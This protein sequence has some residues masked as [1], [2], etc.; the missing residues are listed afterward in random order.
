VHVNFTTQ[1]WKFEMKTEANSQMFPQRLEP[2]DLAPVAA[3]LKACPD[4]TP[5]VLDRFE[6]RDLQSDG[7]S[8]GKSACVTEERVRGGRNY[9]CAK[10]TNHEQDA[11]HVAAWCLSEICL[12]SR[13]SSGFFLRARTKCA[14]AGSVI[15]TIRPACNFAGVA[16][17]LE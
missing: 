5:S 16:Y 17:G 6:C 7:K 11:S 3:R 10:M 4:V 9:G 14:R 8:A 12:S 2:R 1:I 13:C 15:A